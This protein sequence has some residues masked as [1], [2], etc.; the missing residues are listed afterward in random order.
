LESR[1]MPDSLLMLDFIAK[2]K[3]GSPR[4]VTCVSPCPKSVK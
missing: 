1:C 2:E 4:G 3:W